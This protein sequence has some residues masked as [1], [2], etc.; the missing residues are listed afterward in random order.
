MLLLMTL[1][2]PQ[3]REV[4]RSGDS[5]RRLRLMATLYAVTTNGSGKQG[6][7]VY[8]T[9]SDCGN[10][11]VHPPTT[12]LPLLPYSKLCQQLDSPKEVIRHLKP[13]FLDDIASFYDPADELD[14]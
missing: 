7:R 13:E 5:V 10:G 11:S 12:R 8:G 6:G 1:S 2:A 4:D 9:V 3:Y 14:A